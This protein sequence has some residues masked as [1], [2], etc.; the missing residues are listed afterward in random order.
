MK[1]PMPLCV[2]VVDSKNPLRGI[3]LKMKIKTGG[4]I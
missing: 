4:R 2:A 3:D 1:T